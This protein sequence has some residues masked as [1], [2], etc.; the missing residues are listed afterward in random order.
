MAAKTT[1]TTKT[2]LREAIIKKCLDCNGYCPECDSKLTHKDLVE[3]DRER[4]NCTITTCPLNP[5]RLGKNPYKKT[6]YN[7]SDEERERRRKMFKS[8]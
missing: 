7:L 4:K 8:T 6:T 1:K 3:A 2:S 5:Y